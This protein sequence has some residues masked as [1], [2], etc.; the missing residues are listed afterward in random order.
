MEEMTAFV[1]SREWQEALSYGESLPGAVFD[2][3]F[4]EDFVTT[5][6]RHRGNR[7]WFGLLMRVPGRKIGRAELPFVDLLNLK[8]APE[9]AIIARELFAGILPAYHMSKT[10]WITVVLDGSVPGEFRDRLMAK[11]Y[12]LTRGKKR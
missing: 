1:P 6:L 7:K 11:S 5:V 10:H 8:C 12:M 3:P 2:H 4:E 9:D